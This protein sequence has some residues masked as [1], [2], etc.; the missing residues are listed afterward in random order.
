LPILQG[1]EGTPEHIVDPLHAASPETRTTKEDSFATAMAEVFRVALPLMIS[2]GTFSL[3]LFADRTF[4][5]WYDGAAMSASMAAGNLF[6]TL[7]C[8]PVGISGMTGAIISQYVGAKRPEQIGRFLWQVVWFAMAT[9]PMFVAIGW[10]AKWLFTVTGQ[11]AELVD[12]EARYMR[13]L[14]WGATGIVFE[15]GLSGFFAGTERTRVIM[16]ASIAAG[17]INIVLDWVLIFGITLGPLQLAAG[18]IVGAG[19]ASMIS[20]WFKGAVFA[21]LLLAPRFEAIY[22]VRSGFALDFGLLRKLF[23]FGLPSGLMSLT[24]AGGFTAIVLQIGRL[25]DV[26]LRATTMAINFNMIAF[27]PL[28]GMSIAASVLVGRHLL[29]SGPVR[30]AKSVAGALA[31][32]WVYSLIWAVIYLAFP[33]QLMS[34]YRWSAPT[35]GS[36]EAIELARGLLGFVAIYVLVDATQLIVAGALRGAGDTWFVLL[37]GLSAS[38]IACAIG[39]AFE[40]DDGRLIWWWWV[41]TGW[42][43][44]LAIAMTS[45]FMQGSWKR[46]RMV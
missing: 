8:V 43:F 12:M 21:A 39:L 29:E 23:F 17:L 4:L 37:A 11:P 44:L 36:I 5:L 34:L 35:P 27:I 13:L 6:W 38:V 15:A 1:R 42:V 3:V 2:T 19:V 25:G 14:L 9:L 22:R 33:G 24:E 16:W 30:A 46:M 40:P 10:G 31:I 26:P 7:I 18:G 45:R 41:V 20:F 28:V 32:G